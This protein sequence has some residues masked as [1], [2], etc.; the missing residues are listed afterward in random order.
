MASDMDVSADSNPVDDLSKQ[1][2]GLEI[3]SKSSGFLVTGNAGISGEAS[4]TA[5]ECYG[6]MDTPRPVPQDEVIYIIAAHG[7]WNN[8]TTFRG[9]NYPEGHDIIIEAH[10]EHWGKLNFGVLVSEGTILLSKNDETRQQKVVMRHIQDILNG[11]IKV[12][13]RFPWKENGPESP[14]AIFPNLIFGEGGGD[15][16]PFVATIARYYK[17]NLHF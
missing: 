10:N 6:F 2:E 9:L 16:N 8:T 17:G 14:T 15:V 13:Q 7:I 12:F 5:T 1:L 11:G 4:S 3:G